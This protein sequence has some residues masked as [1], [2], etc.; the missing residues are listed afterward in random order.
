MQHLRPSERLRLH[1]LE[2]LELLRER[3]MENPRVF[4]SVARGTD[5]AGSDVDLLVRVPEGRAW[6]FLGL[7][8]E[9]SDLLGVHVDVVS[10]AGLKPKHAQLLR[11]ARPL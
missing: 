2:A 10:E 4:G 9:L 7:S 5:I 11:D 1:R 3:G 8:E 6:D